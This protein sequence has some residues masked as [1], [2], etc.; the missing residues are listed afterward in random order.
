MMTFTKEKVASCARGIIVGQKA[1]DELFGRD[2]V[3]GYCVCPDRQT[4]KAIADACGTPIT[5]KSYSTIGTVETEAFGVEFF[6]SVEM[7]GEPKEDF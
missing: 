5:R 7:V 2:F 6:A 4:V 3:K 1:V